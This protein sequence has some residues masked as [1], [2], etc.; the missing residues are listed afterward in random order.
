MAKAWVFVVAEAVVLLV[1]FPAVRHAAAQGAVVVVHVEDYAHLPD[2]EWQV[3]TTEAEAILGV[4]GVTV[5][6]GS[7]FLRPI[8]DAPR[9]GRV[10][11]ALVLLSDVSGGDGRDSR[12]A[13][14]RAAPAFGRAWVL[15][16]RIRAATASLPVD[17]ARVLGRVIAHELGH[18]LL[19]GDPHA[20]TGIMQPHLELAH[21]ARTGFT[22]EQARR[23]RATLSSRLASRR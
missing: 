20:P 11:L 14:G 2:R 17:P 23:M 4:A 16:N 13:L 18:L 15:A 21:T 7:P 12:D 3:A 22:V 10:H 6:W 8:A 1:A 5:V 9:D 19:P